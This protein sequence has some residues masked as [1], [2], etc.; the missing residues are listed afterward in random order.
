M[1]KFIK[2]GKV[3]IIL[4]GRF[5]GHKA[6]VVRAYDDGNNQRKYPHAIVAG[7]DRYPLKITRG[8]SKRRVAKRSK[9]K[10]FLKAVNYSH[11]MP[12]RYGLDLDLKKVCTPESLKDQAKR[13]Q[14]RKILKKRFEQ[15]FKSGK[16]KWFF[17]KLRF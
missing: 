8:L 16:N 9:V 11:F 5:A 6:V 4:N 15:R 7:I 2:P 3:V 14:T 10:P 1:P 17:Q 13:I 12:T